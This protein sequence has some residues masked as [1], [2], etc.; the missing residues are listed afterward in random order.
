MIKP[1]YY[2][3]F[4]TCD[5]VH[6]LHNAPRP[7]NLDKRTLIK[8][9]FM[10]LY[11]SVASYNHKIVILGDRL[12]EEMLKFFKQFPV[13]ILNEELGNDKSIRRSIELATTQDDD[14]WVYMCEDDYLHHPDAFLWMTDLIE[15]RRQYV[16]QRPKFRLRRG[17]N[18]LSNKPLFIHPPDYPDRYL[19]KY[20][21]YSLI[22]AGK[23]CHWRQVTSTTF[24]ILATAGTFKKYLRIFIASS[25]GAR[26]QYL[27]KK[28]FGG[29]WFGRKSLCLS[30]IPGVATHMHEEVMTP[31]VD[32]EGIYKNILIELEGQ[33]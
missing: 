3:I 23:Y 28:I 10:S 26:D 21:S 4:R 15:N 1:T 7:F 25:R 22:F 31:L 27:S 13:T 20:M 2:I 33:K 18:R 19:R 8:V 11:T 29:R 30:P 32:W 5:V 6:S 16:S 14:V 9:C 17:A 24:T 12:S